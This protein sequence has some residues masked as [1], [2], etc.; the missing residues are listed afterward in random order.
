MPRHFFMA[1]QLRI[2]IPNGCSVPAA[3]RTELTVSAAISLKDAFLAIGRGY[4]SAGGP[5]VLAACH[6]Q[7]CK[8]R[9]LDAGPCDGDLIR[10]PEALLLDE[11]FSALDDPLRSEMGRFLQEVRR[12]FGIPVVLVTHAVEEA[13]LL[14]DTIIVYSHG[15]VARTGSV[16]QVAHRPAGREVRMLVGV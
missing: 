11:P 12:R 4:E 8:R 10:H 3:S 7:P 6:L 15:K 1:R 14:A 13:A 9:R 2:S 16:E 5:T